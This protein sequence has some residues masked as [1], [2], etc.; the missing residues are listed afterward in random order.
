MF[1]DAVIKLSYFNRCA[2]RVG[3]KISQHIGYFSSLRD[4]LTLKVRLFTLGFSVY[5]LQF[6]YDRQTDK[7]INISAFDPKGL[8]APLQRLPGVYRHI[9]ANDEVLYVGMKI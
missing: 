4:F 8:L 7:Q 5:N 2:T 6:K 9:G 3:E 1:Y